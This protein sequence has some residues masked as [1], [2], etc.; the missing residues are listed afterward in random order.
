MT[1]QHKTYRRI[2]SGLWL[3]L[4]A[5]L[6]LTAG[7]YFNAS[8]RVLAFLVVLGGGVVV[9]VRLNRGRELPIA[10]TKLLES[11]NQALLTEQSETAG[12]RGADDEDSILDAQEAREWLDGFLV[13]Q[14]QRDK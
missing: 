14:Q 7:V 2:A 10:G 11:G 1:G 8:L 5:L 13:R 9:L 6:G 12:L 4:G 3:L